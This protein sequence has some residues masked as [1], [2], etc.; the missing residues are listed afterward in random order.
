[1]PCRALLVTVLG[2]ILVRRDISPGTLPGSLW[3][4]A[5]LFVALSQDAANVFRIVACSG[6]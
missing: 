2:V 4:S 3:L 5:K 6:V 1:M